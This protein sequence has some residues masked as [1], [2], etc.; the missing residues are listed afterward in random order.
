[1]IGQPVMYRITGKRL[2][3]RSALGK[4]S[5]AVLCGKAGGMWKSNSSD[6]GKQ[7]PVCIGNVP[8]GWWIRSYIGKEILK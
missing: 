7:G 8:C 3:D 1:M 6:L 4:G 5:P 2:G